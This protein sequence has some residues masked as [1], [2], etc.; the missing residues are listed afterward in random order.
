MGVPQSI[1][2]NCR[3]VQKVD[4][5]ESHEDCDAPLRKSKLKTRGRRSRHAAAGQGSPLPPPPRPRWPRACCRGPEE[6]PACCFPGALNGA[7]STR[8][9]PHGASD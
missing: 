2:Q 6:P 9:P 8:A 5:P 4:P 3:P 7:S 1:R